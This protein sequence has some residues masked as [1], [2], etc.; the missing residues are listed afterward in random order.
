MI[1][2]PGDIVV[3][4]AGALIGSLLFPR[5]HLHLGGGV[6]SSII[7]FIPAATFGAVIVLLI[8]RLIGRVRQAK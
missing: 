7:A 5:L 2:L 6:I 3:G 4:I 1:G 8:A